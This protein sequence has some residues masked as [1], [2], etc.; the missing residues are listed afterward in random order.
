MLHLQEKKNRENLKSPNEYW[1][2]TF[3]YYIN[4]SAT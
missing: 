3:K 1:K 4:V 2:Q